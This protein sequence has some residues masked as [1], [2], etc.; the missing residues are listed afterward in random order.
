MATYERALRSDAF[1]ASFDRARAAVAAE[2]RRDN[3]LV[4]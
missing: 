2:R 4:R 1:A 3:A